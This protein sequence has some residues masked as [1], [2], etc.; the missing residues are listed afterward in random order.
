MLGADFDVQGFMGTVLNAVTTGNWKAGAALLLIFCVYA[1]R[2]LA[3][4]LPKKVAKWMNSDRGGSVYVL[5]MGML[6]AVA[7]GLLAGKP[8]NLTLALSGLTTGAM[9]SG[10][11]NVVWDILFPSDKAKAAPAMT[12]APK[13]AYAPIEEKKTEET[14]T[15]EKTS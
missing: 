14:K 2:K 9:A 6:G 15:E 10:M 4:K 12:P 3:K 7:T 13:E 1:S 8:L 5:V 11:R